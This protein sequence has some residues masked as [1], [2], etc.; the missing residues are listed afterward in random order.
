MSTLPPTPTLGLVLPDPGT[1]QQFSTAT[2]NGWMQTIDSAFAADRGRLGAIETSNGLVPAGTNAQRDAYWGIPGSA[3]ARVALANKAARWYSTDNEHLQMYFAAYNDAGAD[4]L[5]PVKATAGWG[6]STD[7]G[8]VPAEVDSIS[9]TGGTRTRIGK[10]VEFSGMTS[11]RVV[12]C[13]SADFDDYLIRVKLSSLSAAGGGAIR[14]SLAG[15]D[16]ASANYHYQSLVAN[17]ATATAAQAVDQTSCST[18]G[19]STLDLDAD[20]TV[21]GPGLASTTRF[22]VSSAGST[23]T[24]TV[25]ESQIAGKHNVATAFDGFNYFIPGGPNAVGWLAVYGLNRP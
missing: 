18:T 25:V 4:T 14:M 1:G 2:Q 11:I 6:P 17:G 19:V 21:F 20:I 9:G 13:F 22:M 23:G 10:R 8:L 16:D 7:L 3:A 5:T 15:V 12:G 24:K